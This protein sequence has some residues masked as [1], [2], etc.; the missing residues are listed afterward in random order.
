[1]AKNFITKHFNFLSNKFSKAEMEAILTTFLKK[2]AFMRLAMCIAITYISNALSKC[3]F[4][5]YENGKEV[6]NDLA[7]KLNVS[8]NP[9]QSAA[10]FKNSMVKR[11]CHGGESLVYPY[12]SKDLYVA[13]D[14]RRVSQSPKEDYFDDIVLSDSYTLPRAY[15]SRVYF[16]KL[17]NPDVT[18][19][20]KNVMDD[21][22]KLMD[23]AMTGFKQT[24]GRKY[25]LEIETG[26]ANDPEFME[27]YEKVIKKNLKEFLES[28]SAVYPQFKGYNLLDLKSDSDGGASDIIDMRKEIFDVV[29]QAWKIPN[30]MMYGNMTN[31]EDIVRQFLTF[32]LDPV[33]AVISSE[34]TRKTYLKSQWANGCHVQVDTK[35]INHV[36]ILNVADKVEKLISSG[37]FSID[38]VLDELGYQ[39]LETDFSQAHF[40]TKNY[41]LIEEVMTRL[42]DGGGDKQ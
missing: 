16:F 34:L 9:N 41:G 35:T 4:R 26:K 13:K 37:T 5:V 30:S 40:I 6:K 42:G 23:A 19:L 11:M 12:N 10:E 17:N 1:M 2:E 18:R 7:Y 21:Y 31:S 29:A 28:D 25:K 32:A 8:P 33:A 14:F 3:K 39:K 24:R 15:M 20:V 36:D 38:M 27:E 22:G